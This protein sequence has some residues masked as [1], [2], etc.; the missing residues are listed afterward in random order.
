VALQG[1]HDPPAQM[2]LEP[3]GLVSCAESGV[4]WSWQIGVPVEQSVAPLSQTFDGGVGVYVRLAMQGLHEPCEQTMFVP[5][6]LPSGAGT[7]R[8]LQVAWPL[9]HTITP[10]LQGL[11]GGV[12][13]APARH[14][15]HSFPSHV[16]PSSPRRLVSADE[17]DRRLASRAFTLEASPPSAEN[18]SVGV[19]AP[20][21]PINGGTATTAKRAARETECAM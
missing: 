20:P 16:G 3:Q 14:V 13:S 15:A 8:S 5:H 9:P 11:L 19:T 1:T 6:A 12:Q 10:A 4:C 18:K 2:W 21:Q 7:L 17:S